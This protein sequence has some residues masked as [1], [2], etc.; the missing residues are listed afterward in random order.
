MEL[1]KL[2][3]RVRVCKALLSLMGYEHLWGA[4]GPTSDA[5]KLLD[6]YGG[7]MSKSQW[8]LYQVVWYA[9]GRPAEVE[10]QE[11]M[12]LP[13]PY[14]QWVLSL[15]DA[16]LRGGTAVEAWLNQIQKLTSASGKE[17]I[18]LHRLA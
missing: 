11:V 18:K 10:L 5:K 12:E 13:A 3:Q 8:I 17:P 2:H 1:H 9:W 4:G 14:G 7:P 16:T 6:K 15:M